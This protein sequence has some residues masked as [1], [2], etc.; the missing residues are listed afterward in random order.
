M[1]VYTDEHPT[2]EVAKVLYKWLG[3][4]F[5]EE[6]LDSFNSFRKVA[7]NS[8]ASYLVAMEENQEKEKRRVLH[9]TNNVTAIHLERGF[10][11]FGWKFSSDDYD[12]VTEYLIEKF[13]SDDSGEL[14]FSEYTY[15][16][17][18]TTSQFFYSL[19][20]KH[21]MADSR[22]EIMHFF[23]YADKDSNNLVTPEELL[24]ALNEFDGVDLK[25]DYIFYFFSKAERC[26]YRI[27]LTVEEMCIAFFQAVWEMGLQENRVKD[28]MANIEDPNAKI[29]K[30]VCPSK[31][32][33][34]L[35]VKPCKEE[36]DKKKKE[37]KVG[38]QKEMKSTKLKEEVE[39]VDIDADP[40]CPDGDC[41][42]SKEYIRGVAINEFD[43]KTIKDHENNQLPSEESLEKDPSSKISN[44]NSN[45][46]SSPENSKEDSPEE[47][48]LTSLIKRRKIRNRF[49]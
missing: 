34:K 46:N 29:E 30:G 25:Y 24:E 21:C 26:E 37:S 28:I 31:P 35:P 19:H 39:K 22:E 10:R 47:N 5:F 17:F 44:S 4:M 8:T 12:E 32:R 42:K 23:D 13:D 15:L 16:L 43:P 33:K 3:N 48:T 6:A 14:S 7:P 9:K 20:C 40:D 2:R 27:E 49:S 1:I 18:K 38:K 45:S 36:K 11:S 41:G